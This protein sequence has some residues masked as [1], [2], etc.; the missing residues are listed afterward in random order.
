VRRQRIEQPEPGRRGVTDRDD[1]HMAFVAMDAHRCP[2]NRTIRGPTR[3]SVIADTVVDTGLTPSAR[4]M[5]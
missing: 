1:A 4:L 5:S 2:P 3:V